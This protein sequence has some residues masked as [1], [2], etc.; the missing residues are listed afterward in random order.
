MEMTT[1]HALIHTTPAIHD[2]RE[3]NT[4]INTS[5]RSMFGDCQSHTIGLSV[6]K[7]RPSYSSS[8][9]ENE[10]NNTYEAIIKCPS[11]SLPYVRAALTFPL[12]PSYLQD[13]LYRI[14]FIKIDDNSDSSIPKWAE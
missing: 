4:I 2:P 8:Y 11:K 7:C 6:L 14:D 10:N 5:V 13:T 1:S 9:E 12:P 3:L